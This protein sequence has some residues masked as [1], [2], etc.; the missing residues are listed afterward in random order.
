MARTL[1]RWLPDV[2]GVLAVC[3]VVLVGYYEIPFAGKTFDAASQVAGVQGCGTPS[4]QCAPRAAADPRV[5]PYASSW[6]LDPW[7]PVVHQE[8]SA[9]E[10]PLWNP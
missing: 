3:I 7:G 4:G 6:A 1:P 2:L 8:L 5:D 10:T 9:G